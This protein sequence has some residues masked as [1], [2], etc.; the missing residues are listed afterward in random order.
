MN[1]LDNEHAIMS[2]LADHEF[3]G[4]A[5]Y[6]IPRDEYPFSERVIDTVK[7]L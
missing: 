3:W 2:F 6:S 7:D 1:I 5:W 4:M